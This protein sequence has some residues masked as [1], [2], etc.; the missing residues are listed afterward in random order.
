MIGGE[1]A[2]THSPADSLYSTSAAKRGMIRFSCHSVVGDHA[3]GHTSRS[4]QAA[5]FTRI[6]QRLE[7]RKSKNAAATIHATLDGERCEADTSPDIEK[8]RTFAT[9]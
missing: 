1:L 7:S 8:P 4:P 3:Y 5:L 9:K 6:N 2:A